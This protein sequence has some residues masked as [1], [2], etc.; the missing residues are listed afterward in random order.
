MTA[1]AVA[2]PDAAGHH[3]LTAGQGINEAGLAY[4]GGSQENQGLSRLKIR[5]K[6]FKT[7]PGPGAHG[8]DVRTRRGA[9]CLCQIVAGSVRQVGLGQH[10]D[11]RRA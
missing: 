4:A 10:N 11:G 1:A 5:F 6:G 3:D 8:M 2:L 9:L 7:L